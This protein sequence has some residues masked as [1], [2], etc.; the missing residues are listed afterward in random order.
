LENP[1]STKGKTSLIYGGYVEVVFQLA[2]DFKNGVCHAHCLVLFAIILM[3]MI[4]MW[5]LTVMLAFKAANRG[6]GTISFT[7]AATWSKFV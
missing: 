1:C 3:K 7:W 4:G 6:S 2:L 5:C